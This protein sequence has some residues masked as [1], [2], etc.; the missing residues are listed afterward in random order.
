MNISSNW[1]G[2]T[3]IELLLVIAVMAI[4]AAIVIV[5]VNPSKQMADSR[6]AEREADVYTI[7]QALYQYAADHD[8]E[9]PG[10][11]TTTEMEICSTGSESCTGLVDLS[12]LT[13]NQAYLVDIPADPLC[14][15]EGVC[16]V[17]GVG[18]AIQLSN[19][20]RIIIT[21]SSSENKEIL[22]NQ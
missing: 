11:L 1:R 18:Y 20:D 22:I 8:G 6:D 3:L 17:N 12:E 4:L 5:A 7:V 10:N 16:D 21:A 2:F 19:S 15:Q 13:D 14:G 9:F